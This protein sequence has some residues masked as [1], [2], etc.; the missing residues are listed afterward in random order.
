MKFLNRTIILVLSI[1][2]IF[3]L[4]TEKVVGE[5]QDITPP[6][7]IAET[8]AP[9]K[10]EVSKRTINIKHF[11]MSDF[12]MQAVI[13]PYAVHYTDNGVWKDID[14]RIV[15]SSVDATLVENTANAFKVRFAKTT[16]A[17]KL[18]SVTRG[19]LILNW[20][21]DSLSKT[22]I[23]VN[24]ASNKATDLTD[25]SQAKSWVTYPNVYPD[26]DL[27]YLLDGDVLKENF[28]LKS[29]NAPTT[30]VQ[31]LDRKSVV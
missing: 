8:A 5:S 19:S 20:S 22:F 16:N 27:Q 11:L 2:L 25:T 23:Q 30:F 17:D 14:N 10:E 21:L 1:G 31:H 6:D 3:S 26:T 12:T 7:P 28:I 29:A 13:Y 4:A 15:E 9:I 18:V 24:S